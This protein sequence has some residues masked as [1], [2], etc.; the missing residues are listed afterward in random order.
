M[1]KIKVNCSK[2]N[3]EFEIELKRYNLKI[4]R[5]ENFFCS[6]ECLSNKGSVSCNC[7]NCGKK[8][9]KW[10][11]ELEKSKYGNVF[12]SKSCAISFNN[13][14]YRL[15]KKNPNYTNG[16]RTYR[17]FALASFK[18]E[19]AVCGWSEDERI[20]ETHHIDSS[21]E[22]NDTTNLILLCPICHRKITLGLYEL[23]DRHI[24]QLKE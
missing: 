14:N 5:N 16:N 6:K 7:A 21:H 9:I 23:V 13:T 3:K 2:C 11:S 15:N 22:N 10:N 1:T 12:C 20:L 17:S 24:L 8:L 4:K 18:H 19:C